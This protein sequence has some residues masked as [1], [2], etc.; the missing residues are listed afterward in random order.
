MEAGGIAVNVQM[1]AFTVVGVEHLAGDLGVTRLVRAHQA[2]LCAAEQRD[3][4]IKEEEGG[5]H[6]ED[7]DLKHDGKR[8]TLRKLRL[9]PRFE[10]ID[11]EM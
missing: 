3:H 1:G 7:E 4:S 8:G 11:H 9:H 2:K 5:D 6:E 10:A